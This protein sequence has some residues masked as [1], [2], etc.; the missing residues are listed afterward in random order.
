MSQSW[1]PCGVPARP[2][3][4]GKPETFNF[5]GFTF[6]CGKSRWGLGLS[7]GRQDPGIASCH[8]SA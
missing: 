2:A 7:R 4:F 3:R 8:T 5:L 6:V 1:S